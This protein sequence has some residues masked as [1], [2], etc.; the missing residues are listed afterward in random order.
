[1]SNYSKIPDNTIFETSSGRFKKLDAMYY[2]DP[3]TGFQSVVD[4]MFD[5][6]ISVASEAEPSSKEETEFITDPNSRL[7]TRNPNY[8]KKQSDA[9]NWFGEMWGSAL[10]DCGPED[11]EYMH[12]CAIGAMAS[13]DELA[14]VTGL[15]FNLDNFPNVVSRIIKEFAEPLDEAAPIRKPK[16]KKTAKKAVAKKST[17]K[18]S[19][20]KKATK[21]K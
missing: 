19:P 13:M 1:L 12:T 20:A 8:T 15:T 3:Q 10:F 14:K 18:K 21:R 9:E 4:P 11:Y 17:A 5:Q 7:M 16:A 6:T 2:E